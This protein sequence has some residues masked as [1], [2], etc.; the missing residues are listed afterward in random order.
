MSI[1][2][3]RRGFIAGL[4]GAGIAWPLAA[5]AQ[6]GNRYMLHD[7]VAS[8]YFSDPLLDQYLDYILIGVEGDDV[9]ARG[10]SVP[11]ALIFLGAR[12]SPTEGGMK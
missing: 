9:V 10:F 2:L 11:F 5:R 4:G 1:C 12:N 8:L 6:Q 7:P 3:R